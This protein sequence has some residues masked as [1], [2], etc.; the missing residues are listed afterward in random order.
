MKVTTIIVAF[1]ATTLAFP[2]V[3]D[4][5]TEELQIRDFSIEP[6]ENVEDTTE[7]DK[8]SDEQNEEEDFSI[9]TIEVSSNE[10]NSES[11][12]QRVDQ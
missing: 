5:E 3:Q 12:N 9:E 6:S 10:N 4:P 1:L 11:E 2:Q 8:K 7:L